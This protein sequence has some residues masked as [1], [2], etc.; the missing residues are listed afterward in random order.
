MAIDIHFNSFI[1]VLYDRCKACDV[2]TFK[3]WILITIIYFKIV[4]HMCLHALKIKKV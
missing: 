4:L 3:V 1:Q 2:K